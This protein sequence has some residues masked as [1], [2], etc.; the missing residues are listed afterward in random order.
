MTPVFDPDNPKEHHLKIT[1]KT[2]EEIRRAMLLG[3][4]EYDFEVM[5][6]EEKLSKAGN[7]MIVVKMKVFNGGG[8]ER[9]VTDWLMEKMEYKLRH[10]MFAIGKGAAYEAGDIDAGGFQ[11]CCGKLTLTIEEKEGFQPQNRVKDYI[12][13]DKGAASA[14]KKSTADIAKPDTSD[15]P[16]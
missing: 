12:P 8:G 2:E 1:P 5:S 4:G 15:V 7:P 10:F 9:H 16:F 14:A 3:P 6:A 13:Q 11:G